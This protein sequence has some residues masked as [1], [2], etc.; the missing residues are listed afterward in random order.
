ME[1]P[2]EM[3]TS[4]ISPKQGVAIGILSVVLLGVGVW[5]WQSMSASKPSSRPANQPQPTATQQGST[6][7]SGQTA[8]ASAGASFEPFPPRDPFR[9]TVANTTT[10]PSRVVTPPKTSTKSVAREI[11][12][13]PPMP[14]MTLPVPGGIEIKPAGA[15]EAPS[16]PDW[17]LVGVIQGPR[18]LAILKDSEGNRRFVQIGDTLD[19]GWRVRQ[20]ERGRLTLQKGQR[21]ISVNV[22]SST[23]ENENLTSRSTGG[24]SQ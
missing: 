13:T 20:I 22:G 11:S 1:K 21:T 18:T 14:P 6:A 9:P 24:T 17:T 2:Q 5:Q 10:T 8:V 23:A 12:G 3:K 16:T 19:E 4:Q 7:A 15:T